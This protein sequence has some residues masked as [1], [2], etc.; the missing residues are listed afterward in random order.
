[1]KNSKSV[2]FLST[3]FLSS[4]FILSSCNRVKNFTDREL[5]VNTITLLNQN[6]LASRYSAMYPT[7]FTVPKMLYENKEETFAK[8]ST[9]FGGVVKNVVWIKYDSTSRSY[10][11]PTVQCT[12]MYCQ[13]PKQYS[14]THLGQKFDNS[15]PRLTIE[16]FAGTAAES[17]LVDV[18]GSTLTTKERKL[19]EYVYEKL[20]D[21]QS[22]IKDESKI[23]L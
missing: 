3:L 12:T 17:S 18:D 15:K 14:D 8:Q 11:M 19:L 10:I 13:N 21:K 22:A 23:S 16:V 6:D 5:V 1:M 9:F 2:P 4:L 20:S 7:D